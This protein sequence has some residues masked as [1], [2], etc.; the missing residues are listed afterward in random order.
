MSKPFSNVISKALFGNKNLTPDQ[1]ADISN[2]VTRHGYSKVKSSRGMLKSLLLGN[3]Y[4]IPLAKARFAQGGILGK[5]GLILGDLAPDDKF[6]AG[7]RK[8]RKYLNSAPNTPHD[9][10]SEDLK[11]VAKGLP[12]LALGAGFSVGFPLLDASRAISGESEYGENKGSGVGAALGSGLGFALSSGFGLPAGMLA[13]TIGSR[14][15]AGLGGI[16][17]SV[18][19]EPREMSIPEAALRVAPGLDELK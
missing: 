13:S 15:G 1:V 16:F 4:A 3:E 17:D 11:N 7:A 12:G 19:R 18:N 14:V 2:Y 5:G 10:T 9:I 6:I 8:I